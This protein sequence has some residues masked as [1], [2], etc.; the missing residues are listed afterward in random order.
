[1]AKV[2]DGLRAMA[3]AQ[4][5]PEQTYDFKVAKVRIEMGDDNW[6]RADCVI[7]NP[8]DPKLATRRIGYL[9]G[10]PDTGDWRSLQT[11]LWALKLENVPDGEY[12][13]NDTRNLEGAEFEGRLY[14][15]MGN[16]GLEASIRPIYEE[17]W[18]QEHLSE[19]GSSA[20]GGRRRKKAAPKRR[21]A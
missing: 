12:G 1:M 19:D 7:Q 10:S 8:E 13:K 11:L 14:H 15:R 5:V 4:L 3:K 2:T 21:R 20:G 17:A 18:V 16:R 6:E 9:L